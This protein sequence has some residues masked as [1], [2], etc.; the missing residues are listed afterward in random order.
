MKDGRRGRCGVDGRALGWWRGG[1]EIPGKVS[2]RSV[3]SASLF[4]SLRLGRFSVVALNVTVDE[5]RKEGIRGLGATFG[6]GV[7]EQRA[8]PFP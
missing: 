8:S 1:G 7:S 6:R 3:A 5:G 4:T 2:D